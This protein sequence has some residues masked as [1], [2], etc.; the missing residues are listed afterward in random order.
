MERLVQYHWPGNIRELENII[1]RLVAITTNEYIQLH[2]LPIDLS[3]IEP[4]L[5]ADLLEE[6]QSLREA[7]QLFEKHFILRILEKVRWN[8]TLAA[9]ILG[10]HRNTLA[11]RL[12]VL[13]LR[14]EHYQPTSGM[15]T[16]K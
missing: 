10:I 7:V 12:D 4:D 1:E 11:S 8:Q 14:Q 15:K 9:K 6:K 16:S 2:E 3:A 5:T 13:G